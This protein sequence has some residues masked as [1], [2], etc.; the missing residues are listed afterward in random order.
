MLKSVWFFFL[1][2]TLAVDATA[3][4][5]WRVDYGLRFN[6]VYF[7]KALGKDAPIVGDSAQIM[8]EVEL[9]REAEARN[10]KADDNL[11]YPLKTFLATLNAEARAQILFPTLIKN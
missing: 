8:L 7:L 2:L 3:Q 4:I 6:E 9:V 10:G 1:S 11:L 5:Y